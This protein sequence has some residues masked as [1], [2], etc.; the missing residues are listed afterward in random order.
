MID[1]PRSPK[2]RDKLVECLL[3]VLA[4]GV[5]VL[6]ARP[7]AG[8]WND[9]SRLATVESL[10]DRHTWAIDLSTFVQA[11]CPDDATAPLPYDPSDVALCEHGTLDKLFIDGH[12]YSDKSPVPALLMAGCYQLWQWAT[13]WTARTHPDRFC[14]A[15][16]L[17]SSGLA[18]M[19]AVWCVYRLGRCLRLPLSLRLIL[20]AS[21][22][23]ATVA[24]PYAQHVNNHILL[25]G[26][27]SALVLATANTI[28]KTR[29]ERASWR[30]FVVLGS[31]A[32]LSYTI[33]LGVGPVV[34]LCT[35]ILVLS[36]YPLG[37]VRRSL[38]SPCLF[39]ALAALP[40]LAL[41]HGI[42]YA[43]GGT[44]KPANANPE[45]FRWPGSPFAAGNLTGSWIHH[46]MGSF[47]LYAV[48]MLA[49]K[50]GFL[51]HNLPL[52]LTL[53]A[54][55]VLLRRHREHWREVLWAV[56]CCGGPWLLYAATSNNSSGQCLA[57]RWFVPLLAPAYYLLAMFLRHYPQYRIDFL[58]LSAW[59]ALLVLLMGEGPWIRHMVPLF[60]PIQAVALVSWGLCHHLRGRIVPASLPGFVR[61]LFRLTSRCHRHFLGDFP[62]PQRSAGPATL[63]C[64]SRL[65]EANW[66]RLEA[67]RPSKT[68]FKEAGR[69]TS[70]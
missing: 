41:H 60:W 67:F 21:F 53:P 4:A 34:L 31:L 42:N 70:R 50:R 61:V 32:G 45:Y 37:A 40:W 68:S 63:R 10:V 24:L 54:A 27:T 33:D 65:H 9:G 44:W 12:Y 38:L 47:L 46:N 3:V 1:S 25:L 57:I 36:C 69:R 7:Y 29:R 14:T 48:S 52:F 35:S 43:I 16:T 8:S 23:F 66:Q 13:G 49:G 17:I 6:S 62:P 56:A 26:V 58:L 2:R 64:A 22:A 19:L 11:P 15:M 59:G 30:H 5:A 51:G 18:Y 28:E 20:T 55:V 39:F